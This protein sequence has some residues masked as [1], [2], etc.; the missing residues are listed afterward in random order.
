MHLTLSSHLLDYLPPLLHST[1][2]SLPLP[3]NLLKSLLLLTTIP[4]D[5]LPVSVP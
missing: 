1:Y 4:L 2:S 5:P 3:F